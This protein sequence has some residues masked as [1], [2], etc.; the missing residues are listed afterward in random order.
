M[1]EKHNILRMVLNMQREKRIY[2]WEMAELIGCSRAC[3]SKL[4]ASPDK[5]LNLITL[6]GVVKA[7][8]TIVNPNVLYEYIKNYKGGDT[9]K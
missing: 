6:S 2:D 3:Y 7:F 4:K 8:P 9:G 5:G 1:E